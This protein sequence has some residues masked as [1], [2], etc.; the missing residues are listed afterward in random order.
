MFS[1]FDVLLKKQRVLEL[2]E[3]LDENQIQAVT[4]FLEYLLH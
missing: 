2:I 4:A 3:T 1:S